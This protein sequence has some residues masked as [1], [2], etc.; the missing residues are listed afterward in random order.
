MARDHLGLR[1]NAPNEYQMALIT[2]D[3]VPSVRVLEA[4]L[5]SKVRLPS[6]SLPVAAFPRVFPLPFVR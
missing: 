3:G 5:T 1:C 4:L 2:S 6:L